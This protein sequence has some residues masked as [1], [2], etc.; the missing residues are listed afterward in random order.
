MQRIRN[1]GFGQKDRLNRTLVP[2]G[3]L[4]ET[5]GNSLPLGGCCRDRRPA[6]RL[7]VT[8][9]I[10]DRPGHIEAAPGFAVYHLALARPSASLG[11]KLVHESGWRL[12]AN[13]RRLM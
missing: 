2:H 11:R 6:G 5:I 9:S 7:K 12:K 1:E 13:C 3:L 4:N 10:G 8:V